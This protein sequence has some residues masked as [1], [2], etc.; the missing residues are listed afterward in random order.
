MWWCSGFLRGQENPLLQHN[1]ET[2][3]KLHFTCKREKETSFQKPTLEGSKATVEHKRGV[4]SSGGE[5]IIPTTV[6]PEEEGSPWVGKHDKQV[7]RLADQSSGHWGS[8]RRAPGKFIGP[9]VA[10]LEI[11]LFW[12][13]RGHFGRERYPLEPVVKWKKEPTET[14]GPREIGW[15]HYIMSISIKRGYL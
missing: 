7:W 4:C 13:R 15:I 6:P 5:H 9:K 12:K 8:I 14:M 10:G 1:W 11:H 3:Y 2:F